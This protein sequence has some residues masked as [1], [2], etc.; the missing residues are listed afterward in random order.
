MLTRSAQLGMRL[1]DDLDGDKLKIIYLRPLDLSVDE[2]LANLLDAIKSIGA[3][4][5]VIDQ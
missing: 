1:Q 3:Q 4:R 5:V 2:M